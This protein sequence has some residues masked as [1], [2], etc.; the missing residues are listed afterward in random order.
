MANVHYEPGLGEAG[1]SNTPQEDDTPQPVAPEPKG[2]ERERAETED[3]EFDVTN[4]RHREGCLNFVSTEDIA[5]LLVKFEN[6]AAKENPKLTQSARKQKAYQELSVHLRELVNEYAEFGWRFHRYI[7]QLTE[8]LDGQ[9][10][11]AESYRDKERLALLDATKWRR[12]WADLQAG[13]ETS[14]ETLRPGLRQ[15]S[16]TPS[17]F[18]AE[19]FLG[20]QRLVRI[21]DPAPFTG[22][23]D[24]PID[25][26]VFD[27]RNKL[28]QNSYEF[29]GEP[30]KIAYTARLVSGEARDFI[31][32]RLEPDSVDPILSVD[33][34]FKILQQAYG[35]SKEMVRQEAKEGYRRLKQRDKPFPAFW[36]DFNRL[37]TKLGKSPADQ[38]DELLDKMN[39]ELLKSLGD[40][41]FD[42]TR[43]LAEWCMEQENRLLLIKNRQRMEERQVESIRRRVAP[44]PAR[45]SRPRDAPIAARPN[46]F[47]PKE[48]PRREPENK[49]DKTDEARC[50]GCGKTG[51]WKKDCPESN[52]LMPIEEDQSDFYSDAHGDDGPDLEDEDVDRHSSD[53]GTSDEDAGKV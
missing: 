24:Y 32:D 27:M 41:K 16:A 52:K 10:A 37:A 50:Y 45:M 23:D 12:K 26:W 31:R 25:D 5:E 19:S 7:G 34:I 29:D 13:R 14:P 53:N 18:V 9:E 6:Q 44:R 48:P 33:Q 8:Q 28:T 46:F 21:K 38:Y 4:A 17:T 15:E 1:S 43:E 30:L 3:V 22:K 40:K 2:K 20:R 11:L 51:H 36:A 42:T 49:T 35:K 47:R 39:L